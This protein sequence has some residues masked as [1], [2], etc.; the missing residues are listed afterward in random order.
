MIFGMAFEICSPAVLVHHTLPALSA[1]LL[2]DLPLLEL[3]KARHLPL[4]SLSVNP[5][6]FSSNY[7]DLPEGL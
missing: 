4:L 2:P 1:V 7:T 5:L 6:T 3:L